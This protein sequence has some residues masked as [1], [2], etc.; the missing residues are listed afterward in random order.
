MGLEVYTWRG[1]RTSWSVPT[2]LCEYIRTRTHVARKIVCVIQVRLMFRCSRHVCWLIL[3]SDFVLS[4]CIIIH[5]AIGSNISNGYAW[6]MDMQYCSQSHCRDAR[7]H[8]RGERTIRSVNNCCWIP[9]FDFTPSWIARI[10]IIVK[11]FISSEIFKAFELTLKENQCDYLIN[12]LR[13]LGQINQRNE[14]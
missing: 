14:V 7:R 11:N 10:F 1:Q 3:W 8:F 12:R 4:A 5:K 6:F 2:R 9:E 13:I